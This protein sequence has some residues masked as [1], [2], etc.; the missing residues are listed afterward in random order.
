MIG[1]IESYDK[2]LQTGVIKVDEESFN[3]HL[4]SWTEK[5]APNVD[6][7]VDFIEE[8]GEVTEVSLLAEYL[9][10]MK[11][12]KS[13]KIAAFLGIFLGFFGIHRFYLGFYTI[14][15]I[16]LILL[17]VTQGYSVMWGLI[18]GILIFSGHIYKDAQGRLLK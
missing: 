8:E 1:I 13:R 18:D 4:D 2:K 15:V 5:T 3:F 9:K 10:N 14:G 7:D 6:D 11:P 16:Q 12:V 17:F